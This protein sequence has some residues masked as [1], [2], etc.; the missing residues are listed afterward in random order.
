MS[1][2]PASNPREIG[3]SWLHSN[4][5]AVGKADLRQ[6]Y[7]FYLLHVM[8]LIVSCATSYYHATRGIYHVPKQRCSIT[9]HQ[10]S[11]LFFALFCEQAACDKARGQTPK[12]SLHCASQP[13][14]CTSKQVWTTPAFW[15]YI[16]K[17]PNRSQR[18]DICRH[19]PVMWRLCSLHSFAQGSDPAGFGQWE[20][21]QMQIDRQ[22][23]HVQKTQCQPSRKVAWVTNCCH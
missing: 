14:R 2:K 22:P 16:K 8:I 13:W 7:I 6:H 17:L 12:R 11:K 4:R 21:G 9:F 15:F 3:S 5:H 20:R 1:N 19:T 10:Y 18:D 23:T